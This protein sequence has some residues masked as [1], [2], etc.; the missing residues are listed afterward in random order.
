[1]LVSEH[2]I[3]AIS[4]LDAWL[5]GGVAP[6]PDSALINHAGRY[7]GGP[8]VKRTRVN[9]LRGWRYRFRLVSVSALGE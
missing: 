5:A 6:V 1:M 7:S 4:F 3:Y 8:A 9:V 2:I